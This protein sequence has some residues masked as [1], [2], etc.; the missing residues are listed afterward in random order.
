MWKSRNAIGL[1]STQTGPDVQDRYGLL[2]FGKT[3]LVQKIYD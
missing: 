3:D 1:G 2:T